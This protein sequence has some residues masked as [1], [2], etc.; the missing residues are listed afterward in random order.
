MQEAFEEFVKFAGLYRKTVKNNSSSYLTAGNPHLDVLVMILADS[1][2]I[3]VAN[4]LHQ[5][6]KQN[7]PRHNKDK[8]NDFVSESK[9]AESLPKFKKGLIAA[10]DFA[11]TKDADLHKYEHLISR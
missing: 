10:F 5:R 4:I 11:K 1:D 9:F 8:N 6:Y 7:L 2:L 3:Q